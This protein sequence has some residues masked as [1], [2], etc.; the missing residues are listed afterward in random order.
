MSGLQLHEQLR[1]QLPRLW[2]FA[3]RLTCDQRDAATLVESSY[4]RALEI[5]DQWQSRGS[6][7]SFMLANICSMW[8][9]EWRPDI[10]RLNKTARATEQPT[11]LHAAEG[12]M[13]DWEQLSLDRIRQAVNALPEMQRIV[14]ILVGAEGYPCAQ[15]AELLNLPV[16]YVA[17]Q[18]LDARSTMTRLLKNDEAH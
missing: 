11:Y 17:H 16:H 13:A 2:A 9:S 14:M 7:V 18:M 12:K 15:V 3:L 6:A 4:S 5:V 10:A 1:E 8:M